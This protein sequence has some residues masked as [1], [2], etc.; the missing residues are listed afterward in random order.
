MLALGQTAQPRRKHATEL[1][2]SIGRR[3]N[4]QFRRG[5][6]LGRTHVGAAGG[7]G[8]AAGR[9]K[10]G[11]PLSGRSGSLMLDVFGMAE[12]MPAQNLFFIAGVIIRG[13]IF[14][15]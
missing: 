11:S 7:G 1:N 4:R 5:W 12:A 15:A 2:H 6:G 14:A 3:L 13:V 10:L 8:G 9:A